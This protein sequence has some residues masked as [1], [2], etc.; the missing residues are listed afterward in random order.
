MKALLAEPM[1]DPQVVEIEDSL[2]AFQKLLGNRIDIA[3]DFV[4]PIAI[5]FNEESEKLGMTN[6]FFFCDAHCN[7]RYM[8]RGKILVVGV[9]G[10]FP[11]SLTEEQIKRYEQIFRSTVFYF[12]MQDEQAANIAQTSPPKSRKKK[13]EKRYE[14]ARG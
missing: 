12:T 9:S 13:E 2:F 6:V 11:C 1:R 14:C 7:P 5:I 3:D 4:E 8:I 10:E